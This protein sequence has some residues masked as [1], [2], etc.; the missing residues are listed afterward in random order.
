MVTTYIAEVHR[1]AQQEE[2]GERRSRSSGGARAAAGWDSSMLRDIKGLRR[3]SWLADCT[4]AASTFLQRT[5]RPVMT[6]KR[7]QCS[8][9]HEE[10]CG[11][12]A[13]QGMW[14]GFPSVNAQLPEQREGTGAGSDVQNRLL[15][16]SSTSIVGGR[17]T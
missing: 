14:R 1:G 6:Q 16:C 5:P 13:M 3:S 7:Q 10:Q 17:W 11:F 15:S 8:T 2:T 4:A 12:S 9:Q